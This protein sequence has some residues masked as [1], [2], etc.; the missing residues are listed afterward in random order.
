MITPHVVKSFE[1]AELVTKEF[2]EKLKS[3]QKLLKK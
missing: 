1:E 2:S 3:L